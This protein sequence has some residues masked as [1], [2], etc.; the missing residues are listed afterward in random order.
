MK[1]LIAGATGAIGRPLVSALISAGHDATGLTSSPQ[2]LRI[3]RDLG[4]RGVV[5]NALDAQAV[6]AAVSGV[7]PDAVIEELTSLPKR[8]TPEEMQ[9]SAERDRRLRIEGGRNVQNAA[10]AAGARRYIVQS[11]GFFYASAPG[12]AT[13]ADPLALNASPAVSSS[14]RTYTQIEQRVLDAPDLEGVALRYGFFYGPGTWFTNDGDIAHQVREQKRPI[15]ASGQGV[16]SWVHVEDAAAATV[17]ALDCSPGVYNIVDDD[18]SEMSVWLPAFARFVGAPAP[19]RISEEEA[20]RIA[21]PDAVYYATRLRGASNAKA[22][23]QL[24]FA[25]RR[26]E[27]LQT[28]KLGATL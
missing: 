27:W 11:T 25:P 22:K 6:N 21:G 5:A 14:V 10:K 15:I 19:P 28:D 13:E 17:A 12:L 7:R 16:W 24:K 26:L 8:Y 23:R 2:G 3:L 20:L 18:P 4:A 9:A 1:V